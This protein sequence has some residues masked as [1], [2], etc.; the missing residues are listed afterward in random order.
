[1]VGAAGAGGVER[2]RDPAALPRGQP[3]GLR[4]A[5]AETHRPVGLDR[6][7]VFAGKTF[8]I[9]EFELQVAAVTDEDEARQRRGDDH[10]VA[11]RH[12]ADRAADLVLRP[13]HRHHPQGAGEFRNVERHLRGAVGGRP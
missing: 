8:H 13:G 9:V 7:P 2:N 4:R 5:G 12:V 6:D 1:M 3:Q 10:G 11:H